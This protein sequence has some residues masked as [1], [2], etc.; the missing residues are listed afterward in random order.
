M[1]RKSRNAP[2]ARIAED[3]ACGRIQCEKDLP[4]DEAE[5]N[6]LAGGADAQ[7]DGEAAGATERIK[8]GAIIL[9]ALR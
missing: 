8:D 2:D 3:G 1:E 4:C 9:A 6:R 5:S 7:R